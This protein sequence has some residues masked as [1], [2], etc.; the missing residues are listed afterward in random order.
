M[1]GLRVAYL[2]LF[3]LTACASPTARQAAA[4]ESADAALAAGDPERA[5]QVLKAAHGY[6]PRDL[7]IVT[8]WAAILVDQGAGHHA[9]EV[10]AAVPGDVTLDLP[11]RQVLARALI[12]A[13]WLE[14]A[15]PV[16]AAL[17]R[18]GEADPP[19][20]AA[21]FERAARSTFEPGPSLPVAWLPRLINGMVQAERLA[22]AAAALA[23]LPADHPAHP[24]LVDAL[25][26]RAV[27]RDERQVLTDLLAGYE[28]PETAWSLLA[29]HRLLTARGAAGEAA[30]IEKRFLD[31]FPDHPW[32][33]DILLARARRAVRQ[34]Q[35]AAG[36]AHAEEA[37]ALDPLRPEAFVERGLA[38]HALGDLVAAEAAFELALGLDPTN[39]IASRQLTGLRRAAPGTLGTLSVRLE[40]ERP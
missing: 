1:R 11:A 15:I 2:L 28:G 16:L 32:R 3:M 23:R 21:W 14:R 13:G 35:P 29:R 6:D 30:E 20:L 17:E 8:R 18:Q 38:L 19:V 27:A 39:A 34:G 10:L 4:L 37:V 31:R 33:Y 5:A 40:T 36:L 24:E 25:L 22:A 12:A 7:R 26:A 9:V